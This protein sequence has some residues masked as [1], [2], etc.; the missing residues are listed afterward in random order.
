[1]TRS[2]S[3]M[4]PQLAEIQRIVENMP[5]RE[6]EHVRGLLGMEAKAPRLAIAWSLWVRKTAEM[7]VTQKDL[8]DR[9]VGVC[10]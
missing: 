3:N 9:H 8:T 7:A 1:M 5:E 10:G 4:N 2:E 6:L